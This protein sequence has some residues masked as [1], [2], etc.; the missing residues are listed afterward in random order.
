MK[1]QIIKF[2]K[3]I[4]RSITFKLLDMAFERLFKIA[5]LNNDGSVSKKEYNI[6]LSKLKAKA[7]KLKTIIKA[8]K[9]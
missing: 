8:F 4:S 3:K 2:F 6:V 9:Q 7:I 1:K 5:D